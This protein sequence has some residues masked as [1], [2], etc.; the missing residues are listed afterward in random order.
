MRKLGLR[1][2]KHYQ[3]L[4]AAVSARISGTFKMARIGAEA[5][6]RRGGV[7]DENGFHFTHDPR[8]N[9][10]FMMQMLTPEQGLEL[11]E[12]V[13]RSLVL[14]AGQATG[15]TNRGVAVMEVSRHIFCW[16]LI[17]GF[18]F[19]RWLVLCVSCAS[20]HDYKAP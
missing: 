7:E 20:L 13:P 12:Q 16:Q 14:C 11:M 5:L 10:S 9:V 1:T 6:V 18:L 15:D 2:P 3:S 8:A 4:D 17:L 19:L